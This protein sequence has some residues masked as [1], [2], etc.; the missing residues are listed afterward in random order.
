[1]TLHHSTCGLGSNYRAR[2]MKKTLSLCLWNFD[3]HCWRYQLDVTY[4]NSVVRYYFYIEVDRKLVRLALAE[5]CPF[6]LSRAAGYFVQLIKKG[7]VHP[8]LV[9]GIL[10]LLEKPAGR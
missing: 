9:P 4:C 1:M 3:L 7:P 10:T 5:E 6:R 8:G 2:L